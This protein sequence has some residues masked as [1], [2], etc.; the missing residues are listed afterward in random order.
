MLATAAAAPDTLVIGV[1]ANAAGMAEASRRAAKPAKKGGLPN[2]LFV[3]AAAESLPA[4][5]DGCAGALTVHFPWGSLLRGLLTAEPVVLDGVARITRPGATVAML[6]SVTARDHIDGLAS[7]DAATFERLAPA[8]A[9]CGLNLR[10][11][12]PATADDL[13]RSHSS[14]AKR[15]GA[16]TERVAWYVQY[17]RLAGSETPTV[18]EARLR[19]LDARSAAR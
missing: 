7:L 6:F 2:A 8:Y 17:E 4:E 1:D 16:G 10:V 12:R 18:G 11:A 9:D 19:L 14:W 5:L 3:V 15:L 13:V